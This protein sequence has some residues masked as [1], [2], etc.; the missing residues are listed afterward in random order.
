[1]VLKSFAGIVILSAYK[2]VVLPLWLRP[3]GKYGDGRDLFQPIFAEIL[4]FF[5]Q[6]FEETFSQCQ[7]MKIITQAEDYHSMKWHSQYDQNKKK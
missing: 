2:N 5:L 4:L 6:Y 3:G 1:M 7:R